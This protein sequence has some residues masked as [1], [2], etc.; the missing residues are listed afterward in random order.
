MRRARTLL[1]AAA[2][3]AAPLAA[4]PPPAARA[5]FVSG[6]ASGE[7]V[8]ARTPLLTQ[9]ELTLDVQ[10]LASDDMA[11]RR[12]GTPGAERA[13]RY[14]VRQFQEAGLEAPPGEPTYLQPFDFSV[15]VELGPDN[16]LVLQH[17]SRLPT[18]FTPGLDF[19]PLGGSVSDR[20][21][22]P[23]VFAGYGISAPSIGY[24][25]YAGLD[26]RG[27]IVLALRYAPGGDDPGGRFGRYLSE[28]YKAAT[29]EAKGARAILFVNPPATEEIDRL[30]PFEV[31]ERPGSLGIVALAVTQGVAR[32]I[33]AVGGHD[34]SLLQ[35]EI[36]T[37]GKPASTGFGEAVL[38]LR[39]DVR[40]RTRTTYNVIGIVPGRDPDLAR[41]AVVVGAH[42]DGLGLGGPG[43]L[44]PVPGEIHNGAD[45]NASGVAAVLEMARFFAYP[46]NR[47]DRTV[48]FVAFGA[49]E[50]GMLGSAKFVSDPPVPLDRVAAMVNMDMIGRL[51]DEL[52]VYGTGSSAAW[53]ELLADADR[54][55]DIP[56]RP[57]PDSYGPSDQAA[58]YQRQVPVVSF[59]T[60]VH[61]DYHRSTDDAD[62]VNEKGLFA[63]TR[64]IRNLV[65]RLANDPERPAFDP[66][67]YSPRDLEAE[68]EEPPA[69]VTRGA[70]LGAVPAPEEGESAGGVEIDVVTEGSPAAAAGIRPGD[71]IVAV[72]GES[73]GNVYDYRRALDELVPGREARVTVERD[74][75]RV[76][77][78]VTPASPSP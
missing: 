12:A 27:K 47:P 4:A 45:D 69:T 9:E 36:D 49:E 53:P 22:Q 8:E 60:G 25:D 3:A 23:V 39:V 26:V 54:H 28:R 66:R 58:F 46:T 32:R 34:L 52:T 41:E 5:Q 67:S 73:I 64:L 33:A 78:A 35:H 56:L 29:A 17:G 15:G 65:G 70:R 13:A 1:I 72:A 14:V 38:N 16:R 48:V 6:A 62:R 55:L 61:P 63:V 77:L 11:G 57:I 21:V 68:E 76:E 10:T 51:R 24:D 7:G 74:G 44:D 20:I 42:Y 31:D 30:I 40:S 19:L 43:S 2:L 37:A 50:E 18:I 71:R 75:R 59:F